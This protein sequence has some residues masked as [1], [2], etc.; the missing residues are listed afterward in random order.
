MSK[1]VFL[2]KNNS[3]LFIN[4]GR[5]DGGMSAGYLKISSLQDILCKMP[6][7]Y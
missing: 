2:K 1:R 3:N 7:V 4:T 6:N 5:L